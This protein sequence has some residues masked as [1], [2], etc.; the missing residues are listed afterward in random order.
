MI[1]TNQLSKNFSGLAAVHRLHLQVDAGAIYGFLGPNGAG[2]TTSLRM[3]MGLERPT[4]GTATIA[5][6]DCHKESLALKRLIG[7]LPDVPIFP[8]FLKGREVLEMAAE[9]HGQ[10]RAQARL[11]AAELIDWLGLREAAEQYTENYSIGMLKRLGLSCAVVHDPQVLLLDEPTNGLD[12]YATRLVCD[13][14]QEQSQ[15]GK[16][17]V[18]STHQLDVAERVCT[19]VGIIHKGQLLA[20][21]TL[22]SLREQT[23][24]QRLEDIFFALT[25]D[26]AQVDH[27]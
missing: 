25:M 11:R 26:P 23:G 27:A 15:R 9:L 22:A 19:H 2:K 20:Q 4:E 21:G 10:T 13:W 8:R 17:I 24:A 5:G 7:Y 1:S 16:T 14:V 18:L 12:P 3:L 6:L